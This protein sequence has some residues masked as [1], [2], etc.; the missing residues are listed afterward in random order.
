VVVVIGGGAGGVAILQE[1]VAYARVKEAEV[2][3]VRAWLPPRG[4]SIAI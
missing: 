4:N 2:V 1:A 3:A